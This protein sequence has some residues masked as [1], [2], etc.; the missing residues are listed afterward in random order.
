MDDAFLA[1]IAR[2]EADFRVALDNLARA[3]KVYSSFLAHATASA[4]VSA[5]A[6]EPTK[7]TEANGVPEETKQPLQAA[8]PVDPRTFDEIVGVKPDFLDR[9]KQGAAA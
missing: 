1:Y 9:R 5:P 2:A 6:P 4:T 3:R 7:A 8:P